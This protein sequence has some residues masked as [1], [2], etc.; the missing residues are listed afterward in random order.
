MALVA[1]PRSRLMDVAKLRIR[2]KIR[3]W[4]FALAIVVIGVLSGVFWERVVVLPNFV[5]NEHLQAVPVLERELVTWFSSDSW[6]SLLGIVLG[7]GIG[8]WS[9]LWFKRTGW[10][11]TLLAT[12]GALAAALVCWQ[13][14]LWM[15][16][17]SFEVRL[18]RAGPGDVLPI[19]FELRAWSAIFLWPLAAIIPVMLMS[20]FTSDSDDEADS[21]ALALV[22]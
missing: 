7:L 17:E 10:V 12:G 22:E 4:V 20:V 5:L 21:E 13:V 14:G 15:A 6:F 2:P 19:S 8:I 1:W 9:W 18:A 16:P 3:P 11:V